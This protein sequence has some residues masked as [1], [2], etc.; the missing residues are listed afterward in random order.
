MTVYSRSIL[1]PHPSLLVRACTEPRLGARKRAYE[2]DALIPTHDI[3]AAANALRQGKLVAFPTET[4][5]GL[6]ADAEN[7]DAVARV[8]AVKGRPSNHPLIVHVASAAELP[9]WAREVPAAAQRLAEA[10]WPGPLT[11]LLRK[12]ERVPLATTGGLDSVGLRVPAHPVALELLSRFGGGVAAPSANRFG[13]VSPTRAEHVLVDLGNDIDLLLDGGECDVGVES[14]ILDLTSDVPRLLRPGGVTVE[15]IE[16]LLG[17]GV[18]R[19]LTLGTRAPGLLPS[20]YAP[21]ARVVIVPSS[22]LVA[23]AHAL[24]AAG[25]RVAVLASHRD[26]RN[27]IRTLREVIF[28]DLGDDAGSAAQRLY[29]ALREADARAASV[30]LAS[31]P[32]AEG[33]GEALADRLKKAAGPRHT[34]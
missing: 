22:A 19:A 13:R 25:E 8:F 7:A 29:G 21:A 18:S 15:H 23:E 10:C 14:T 26:D 4:V 2:P 27:V 12:S 33:L 28:L 6:G 1:A 9:R 32:V 3:Q 17:V 24:L 5:Y 34:P 20:H 31:P 16:S 30:V 11:L